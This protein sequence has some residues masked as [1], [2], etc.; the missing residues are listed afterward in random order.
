MALSF[1]RS[2]VQAGSPTPTMSRHV[3]ARHSRAYLTV[4]LILACGCTRWQVLH[5][6]QT[7]AEGVTVAQLVPVENRRFDVCLESAVQLLRADQARHSS[8]IQYATVPPCH[9]VE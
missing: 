8:A 2:Y 3:H 6:V 5:S 7:A 4:G 1:T 9:G